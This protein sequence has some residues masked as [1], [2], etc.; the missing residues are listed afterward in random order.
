M[1]GTVLFNGDIVP[2]MLD[3]AGISAAQDALCQGWVSF[4]S[5]TNDELILV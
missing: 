3:G 2:W 1:G 4:L 5:H